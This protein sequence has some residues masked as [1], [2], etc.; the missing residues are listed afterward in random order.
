MS[1]KGFEEFTV[2]ITKEDLPLVQE[3]AKGLARRI[4]KN[5]A[6]SNKQIC[7]AYKEKKNIK[8]DGPKVRKIVTYIRQENMVSR[9]CS[10]SKGYYVA[11]NDKEWKEWIHSFEQRIKSMQYTLKCCLQPKINYE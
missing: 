3:I 9:L 2:D 8:L 4:G 6:I 7:N 1:I 10:N 5:N 11:A